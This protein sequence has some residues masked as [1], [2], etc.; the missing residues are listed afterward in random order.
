M[1]RIGR[2]VKLYTAQFRYPGPDRVDIT[3]GSGRAGDYLVLAPSW[4][5]LDLAH[6]AT[7]YAKDDAERDRAWAE[8]ETRYVEEM[9]RSY[10]LYRAVWNKL[11]ARERAVAVCYCANVL[12]CH[13]GLLA[14]LL[15]K[16]GA[17]YA[18]EVTKGHELWPS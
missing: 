14:E 13:R 8:Y 15:V 5:L 18:G 4:N 1:G 16:A 3:R 12:R 9:R 10:R 6:R 7:R 11:L 2:V 17:E